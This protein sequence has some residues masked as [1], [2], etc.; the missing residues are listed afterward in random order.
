MNDDLVQLCQSLKLRRIPKILDR[1]L[2]RAEKQ[3]PSYDEFLARL[4]REE[5]HAFQERSLGHFSRAEVGQFWRAL[6]SCS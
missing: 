1:E 4:L 6:K 2:R 3:A 5:L